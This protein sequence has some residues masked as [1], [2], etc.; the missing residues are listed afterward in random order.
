MTQEEILIQ[1]LGQRSG[2]IRGKGI[3]ILG[4]AKGKAQEEQHNIV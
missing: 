3:T 2:Y 4:Y 1:V